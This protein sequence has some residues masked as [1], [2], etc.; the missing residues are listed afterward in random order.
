MYNRMTLNMNLKEKV[1]QKYAQLKNITSYH[2]YEGEYQERC[3]LGSFLCNIGNLNETKLTNKELLNLLLDLITL[4]GIH[5]ND[6]HY[7]W[8]IVLSVSIILLLYFE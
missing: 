8:N 7:I 4:E 6:P 3:S 2:L 5:S 1:E